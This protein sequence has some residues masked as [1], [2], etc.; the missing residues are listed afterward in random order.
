M[1]PIYYIQIDIFIFLW[2]CVEQ[3]RQFFIILSVWMW[4]EMKEEEE[5]CR[6]LY[7][8]SYWFKS[9][10]RYGISDDPAIVMDL[11]L[12]ISTMINL[13]IELLRVPHDTLGQIYCFNI[14]SY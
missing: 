7:H 9:I 14:L 11:D 1:Y 4:T 10:I 13:C 8:N 2:M 6:K 12:Y 5:K 3:I